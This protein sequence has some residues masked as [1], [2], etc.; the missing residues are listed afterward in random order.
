MLGG[1]K[2]VRLEGW[3]NFQPMAMKT[4]MT[5][6]F[7]NTMTSLTLDDACVPLT[8]SSE[9]ATTMNTAGRLMKPWMVVPSVRRTCCHGEA[10]R[11][12][13]RLKP[14]LCRSATKVADQPME[15]VAA[16]TAYSS[17]RSQPMIHAS[18]SPMVA[19]E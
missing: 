5:E 3:M 4:T 11:A 14:K 6:T 8:R 9:M 7:R 12:G 2:G 1:T 16:P 19:Y 18:N 10:T 17:T 13:G 15:T